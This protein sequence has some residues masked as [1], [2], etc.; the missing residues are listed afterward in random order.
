MQLSRELSISTQN[1]TFLFN[2]IKILYSPFNKKTHD[3]LFKYNIEFG[4]NKVASWAHIV[5]FYNKDSR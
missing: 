2:G 3:N 5:Q 4:F 1:S